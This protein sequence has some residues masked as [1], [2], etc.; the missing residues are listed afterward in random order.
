MSTARRIT[1]GDIA[2]A[3]HSRGY[4]DIRLDNERFFAHILA[5]FYVTGTWPE[6]QID[7]KNGVRNDNRFKNLRAATTQQNSQNVRMH[8]DNF[9]GFKGVRKC[10][11]KYAAR[12]HIDGKTKHLGSFNTPEEA[13]K[14]YDANALLAFGEYAATNKNLGRIK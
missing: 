3:K 13:A 5:W 7:H 6:Y 9:T 1:A 12:I 10:R 14:V 2:G 11:D 8:R 4:I